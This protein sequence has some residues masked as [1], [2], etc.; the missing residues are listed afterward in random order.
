MKKK[1]NLGRPYAI[2]TQEQSMIIFVVGFVIFFITAV[3]DPYFPLVYMILYLISVSIMMM[4]VVLPNYAITKYDLNVEIDP[5]RNPNYEIVYRITKNKK[6]FRRL[7]QTGPLGQVKGL[8]AGY[9]SDIINT[10][11]YTITLQNGNHAI[12][13]PDVMST[14]ANLD[15]EL[16][17]KLIRKKHGVFGFNAYRKALVENEIENKEDIIITSPKLMERLKNKIFKERK[18]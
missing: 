5:M 3:N 1:V 14:N 2:T 8:V 6:I 12:I 10:G 11:S 18:P 15:E 17:W 13:S 16:G 9:N 7:Q 4:G